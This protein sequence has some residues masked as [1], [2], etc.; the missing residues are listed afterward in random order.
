MIYDALNNLRLYANINGGLRAVC[1]FVE[2]NEITALADG[3]YE[4]EN[5]VYA[6]VGTHDTRTAG[7]YEAH[8]RY[9]DLQLILQGSEIIEYA[10]LSDMTNA[11]AYDESGDS[12]LFDCDPQNKICLKMLPMRFAFLLP[13]DAHKP[14]MYLN[15][16]QSRKI[17]FKIPV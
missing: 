12:I 7:K 13:E 10:H 15:D 3:R 16:K 11:D 6:M 9:A 5:G 1:A 4:L 14:L 8:R 17:I 2:N